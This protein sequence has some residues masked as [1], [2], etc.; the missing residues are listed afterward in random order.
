[1]GDKVRKLSGVKSQGILFPMLRNLETMEVHEQST[2]LATLR[3]KPIEA[4]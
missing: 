4:E 1:M 3:G 2:L